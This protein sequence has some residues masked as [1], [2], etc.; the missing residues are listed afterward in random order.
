MNKIVNISALSLSLLL[1]GV[2][3]A[4]LV[5]AGLEPALELVTIADVEHQAEPDAASVARVVRDVAVEHPALHTVSRRR[6]AAS[7][8]SCGRTSSR[9]ARSW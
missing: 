8:A 4:Q 1:F 9:K 2:G 3:A 7:A 5:D 6:D